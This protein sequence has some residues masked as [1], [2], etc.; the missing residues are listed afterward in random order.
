MN[1]L[2]LI[3]LVT[4]IGLISSLCIQKYNVSKNINIIL[5]L[6]ILSCIYLYFY[7]QLLKHDNLSKVFI[8]VKILGLIST[9]VCGVILFN[10]TITLCKVIGILFCILSIYLLTK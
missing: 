6:A 2:Y 7:I 8:L 1:Q 5:I 9:I 10:D 3:L 4:I